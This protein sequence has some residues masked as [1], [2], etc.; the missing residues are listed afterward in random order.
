MIEE[1]ELY[2]IDDVCRSV[3]LSR[4]QLEALWAKGK[5]PRKTYIGA[6]VRITARALAE[7]LETIENPD[8][9]AQRKAGETAEMLREKARRAGLGIKTR[10]RQE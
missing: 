4:K 6:R 3:S 2:T 5:G 1:K 9:E 8:E 10:E 7:W